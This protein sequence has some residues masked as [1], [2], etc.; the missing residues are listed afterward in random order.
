MSTEK[1]YQDFKFK[2]SLVAAI[3]TR[4]LGVVLIW[5]SID[6]LMG[7]H[8]SWHNLPYLI[9]LMPFHLLLWVLG[10][11]FLLGTCQ[12]R[13]L[14]GQFHF[15]RLFVWEVVPLESITRVSKWGPVI[16]VKVVYAGKY[17][18][19]IFSPEDLRVHLHPLP[20]IQFLREVC[21]RNAENSESRP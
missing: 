13:I 10:G 18:Q 16:Y 7:W 21:S 15:R 9:I 19:L 17:Y 4:W 20:L 3:S 12:I 6:S 14:D 1:T 5:V 2:S 8:A 11:V